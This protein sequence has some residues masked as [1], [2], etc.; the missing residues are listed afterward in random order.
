[1]FCY[2]Q[3]A[4]PNGGQHV[5]VLVCYLFQHPLLCFKIVLHTGYS[6]SKHSGL[7]PSFNQ[8]HALSMR[9]KMSGHQPQLSEPELG[10]RGPMSTEQVKCS[11]GN[12]SSKAVPSIKLNK[13][14]ST[15]ATGL[16]QHAAEER[17]LNILQFF[18]KHSVIFLL[19]SFPFIF[20]P[21]TRTLICYCASDYSAMCKCWQPCLRLWTQ[22]SPL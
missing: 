20:F 5:F 13:R 10:G 18:R 1:M 4:S 17:L 8:S 7:G 19:I 22:P 15:A 9:A 11:C 12:V 16:I 6:A 21:H 2:W 3:L 14:G